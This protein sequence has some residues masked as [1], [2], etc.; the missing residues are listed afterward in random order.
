M[1]RTNHNPSMGTYRCVPAEHSLQMLVRKDID[2]NG[3]DRHGMVLYCRLGQERFGVTRNGNESQAR[4]GES[5]K[6]LDWNG[7]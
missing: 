1:I 2:C 4:M 3:T 7:T 6:C 5:G